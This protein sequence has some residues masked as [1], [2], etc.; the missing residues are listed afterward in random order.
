MPP[1]VDKCFGSNRAGTKAKAIEAAL[2]YIEVENTGEFVVV[3]CNP[4]MPVRVY[5]PTSNGIS[6]AGGCP[7]RS[8]CEATQ[9]GGSL[10][11]MFGR[12]RDVSGGW[13]DRSRSLHPSDLFPFWRNHSAF[14]IKPLGKL[15]PLLKSLTKI[16][17][18]T[19]KTV[20]AEV[21]TAPP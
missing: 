1:I 7:E 11:Q 5:S 6:C 13:Y 21:C 15:Q 20:R 3:G 10:G 2:L 4:S 8:R 17:G 19:D 18:H 16:F 14:G 12:H 9:I